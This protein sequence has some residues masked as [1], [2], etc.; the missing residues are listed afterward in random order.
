MKPHGL[1]ALAVAG[2]ALCLASC[3]ERAPQF[4]PPIRQGWVPDDRVDAC[5]APMMD[6]PMPVYYHM[7]LDEAVAILGPPHGELKEMFPLR[8]FPRTKGAG[9]YLWHQR[10]ATLYLVYDRRAR[11]VENMIVVDDETNMGVEILLTRREILS[12]RVAPGMNVTDVY[13]IMGRPDRI[14]ETTARGGHIADRFWYDP[15]GPMAP[16]MYI[17]IDRD[18]LQVT[19]VS[20][21][22]QE[23]TG[24]PDDE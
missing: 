8:E 18:S 10:E 5:L 12:T 2:L 7:P 4:R 20:T 6:A 16:V 15:D 14:D 3:A 1:A 17:E 19:Y 22:P 9:A 21:A 23:E 11:L 24:P 13:R